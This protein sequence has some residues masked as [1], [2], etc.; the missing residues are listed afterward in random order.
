LGNDLYGDDAAGLEVVRRLRQEAASDRRSFCN[1]ERT[2][3]EECSLSG[4]ALLDII[5]GYDT[6]LIIDTIKKIRPRTGRIRLLEAADLRALPGPSPHYVS[7][8]QTIEI[9][10]HL[11]LRVP[12]R[13]RIVAVEAKNVYH[14]GEGLTPQMKKK[15]PRI[16]ERA[17]KALRNLNNDAPDSKNIRLRKR[18]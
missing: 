10:R 5:T 1:P 16:V 9:G 2:D 18:P 7:I 12:S 6:L 4:L 14:L 8:P 15:I 17:K 3:F 13:I 11:G